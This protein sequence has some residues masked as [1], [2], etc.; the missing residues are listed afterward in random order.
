MNLA[1]RIVAVANPTEVL[2]DEAV[3]HRLNPLVMYSNSVGHVR[4]KGF[5]GPRELFRLRADQS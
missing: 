2:V 4:L 1:A 5:D 3:Q